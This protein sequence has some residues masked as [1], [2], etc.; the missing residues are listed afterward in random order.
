ML[1]YLGSAAAGTITLH[2]IEQKTTILKFRDKK[3][4]QTQKTFVDLHT[5]NS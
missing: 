5:V 4:L 1:L 3:I 2:S